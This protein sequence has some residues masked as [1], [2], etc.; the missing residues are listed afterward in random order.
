MRTA[1]C[2]ITCLVLLLPVLNPLQ[3]QRQGHRQAVVENRRE[4]TQQVQ[5]RRDEMIH[6]VRQHFP[7]KIDRLEALRQG[8]PERF[9]HYREELVKQVRR[10]RVLEAENPALFALQVEEL[11]LRDRMNELAGRVREE[12]DQERRTGLELQLREELARS[13]ELRRQVKEAE[14]IELQEKLRELKASLERRDARR[15][16]LIETRFQELVKDGLDDW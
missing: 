4:L 16:E 1:S 6:F 5:E 12:Q 11:R 3:A 14:L 10:L 7:E 8:N 9:Q 15:E 13:F 2:L